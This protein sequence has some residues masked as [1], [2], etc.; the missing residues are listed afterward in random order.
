MMKQTQM[1]LCA[2]LAL[3]LTTPVFAQARDEQQTGQ[4]T[5]AKPATPPELNAPREIAGSNNTNVKIEMTITD[6]RSEGPAVIKTVSATVADRSS[7]RIRT[8]GT[9]RTPMG[10][11]EVILNVDTSPQLLNV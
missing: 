4:P 7:A 6:Q 8:T 11:R 1:M 2:T 9:V 10:T 3:A 5:A